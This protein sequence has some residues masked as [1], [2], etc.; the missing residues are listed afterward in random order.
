MARFERKQSGP[1]FERRGVGGVVVEGGAAFLAAGVRAYAAAA[2]AMAEAVGAVADAK[3]VALDAIS[4]ATAIAQSSL[5]AVQSSATAAADAATRAEN[6]EGVAL[7][8]ASEVIADVHS[9]ST[10]AAVQ[11]SGVLTPATISHAGVQA[12]LDSAASLGLKVQASGAY[13]TNQTLT[14]AADCDLSGL[15]IT[16]TGTGTAV[17]VGVTTGVTWRINA[18]TPAVVA[19][20]KVS[21]G[22]AGVAGTVGV[23]LVNLNSCPSIVVGHVRNFETNLLV[24]GLGTGFSYNNVHLGHLE[25]GKVNQRLTAD[26]TGWVNQNLFLGGRFFHSSA[27]G[28]NVTGA[29]Q[30][31]LDV[32][33]SP[34]NTNTWVGSSFESMAAEYHLEAAGAV[35]VWTNCRWEVSSGTPRV[36]WADGAIRNFIQFGYMT[37]KIVETFGAG[38]SDNTIMSGTRWRVTGSNPGALLVT[39]NSGSSTYPTQVVMAANAL[40][41]DPATA[42]SWAFTA[43]NIKGKRT[44]DAHDRVR[45]DSSAGTVLLGSG[46][47]APIVQIGTVA[48]TNL[49]VSDSGTKTTT[50]RSATPDSFL[51]VFVNGVWRYIP[52]H[53]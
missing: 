27:E 38:A 34:I 28:T 13:T 40:T 24:R 46:A 50:G 33:T 18:S 5:S 15:T 20:G 25:N 45:L 48:G 23:D 19:A 41:S 26:A 29:R 12:A 47:S 17:R 7:A 4:D 37:D 22:W 16:Y 32:T 1:R 30:V 51:Q 10:T 9:N 42:Y 44:T 49:S 39:G 3:G 8:P 31:Q 6:A 36:R 21:A 11:R 53:T 43:S 52:L 14:I 2:A 35:N